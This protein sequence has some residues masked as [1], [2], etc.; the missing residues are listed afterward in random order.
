MTTTEPPPRDAAEINWDREAIWVQDAA[1]LVVLDEGNERLRLQ[2]QNGETFEAPTQDYADSHFRLLGE[3]ILKPK[4][5]PIQA[6]CSAG[7]TVLADP[8]GGS[9]Q[10]IPPGDALLRHR[11]GRIETVD[12]HRF[13]CR[14][15]IVAAG[16]GAPPFAPFQSA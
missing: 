8:E 10:R 5:L 3:A 6:L 16:G 15:R 12:R 2:R 9:P 11:D 13:N 7:E 14:Y 4:F 1:M